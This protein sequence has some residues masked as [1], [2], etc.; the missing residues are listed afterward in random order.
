MLKT[1]ETHSGMARDAD[2]SVE[3]FIVTLVSALCLLS[4]PARSQIPGP[5][6]ALARLA[7]NAN[8]HADFAV[9]RDHRVTLALQILALGLV[10]PVGL[11]FLC[12]M[13]VLLMLPCLVIASGHAAES[14]LRLVRLIQP[15]S[16]NVGIPQFALPVGG[17][18]ESIF[19]PPIRS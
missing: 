14:A 3:G 15:L 19:R 18:P 11:V 12:T 6:E 9:S 8:R 1:C 10:F 17:S 2:S 4:S 7:E 16:F 13:T 5:Q